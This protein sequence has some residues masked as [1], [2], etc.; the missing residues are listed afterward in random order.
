MTPTEII[1]AD[2][3]ANRVDAAP[4]LKAIHTLLASKQA[5]LMQ[6]GESVLFLRR[7]APGK[8]S[9]DL[10]TQDKPMALMK[11]IKDFVRRIRKSDVKHVY[12][13]ANNPQI[14]KAIEAVG[15]DVKKSD[16]AKFNWMADV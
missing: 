8:V 6:H 9:L 7:F 16:N 14:V 5:L 13:K 3:K 2:L 12:G 15:V 11:A 10:Y 1:T 4:V